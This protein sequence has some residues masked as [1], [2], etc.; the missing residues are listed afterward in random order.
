[1]PLEG[2]PRAWAEFQRQ[3]GDIV[4]PTTGAE[5]ERIVDLMRHVSDT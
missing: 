1:M 4:H 2:I 5:Y 3:V